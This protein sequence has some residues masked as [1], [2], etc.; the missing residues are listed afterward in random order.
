VSSILGGRRRLG[1]YSLTVFYLAIR[2][3][4]YSSF[5]PFLLESLFT[6]KK[7]Q[8]QGEQTYL[9]YS[10]S[11]FPNADQR[12]DQWIHTGKNCQGWS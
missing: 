5:F 12:D 6:I 1:R 7:L 9:R 11:K 8:V 4:I 3:H 2:Y 10:L